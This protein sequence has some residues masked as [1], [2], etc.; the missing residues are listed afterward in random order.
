MNNTY[1]IKI[2]LGNLTED[3]LASFNE[4][5]SKLE[6]ESVKVINFE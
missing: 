6:T 4:L 5:I 3:Q 2:I 1:E